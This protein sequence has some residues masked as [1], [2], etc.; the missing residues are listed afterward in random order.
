MIRAMS[1]HREHKRI[2]A[3]GRGP[4]EE[5]IGDLLEALASDYEDVRIAAVEAL[6][7]L[8]DPRTIEP[9]ARTLRDRDEDEMVRR[10]ALLALGDFE[11]ETADIVREAADDPSSVV[12]AE[13][14]LLLRDI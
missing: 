5:V 2:H 10:E 7:E 14:H 1:R 12:S 11:A 3:L 13:A 9:L 4:Y 8:D 6:D